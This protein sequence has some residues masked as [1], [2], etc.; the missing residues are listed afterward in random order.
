MGVAESY[1]LPLN[2]DG[3]SDIEEAETAA[4]NVHSA[5]RAARGVQNGV[6][7]VA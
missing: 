1:L 4:S 7:F 3:T 6:Q 2:K 5:I